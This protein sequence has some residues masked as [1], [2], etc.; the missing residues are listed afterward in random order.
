MAQ[1]TTEEFL[2]VILSQIYPSGRPDGLLEALLKAY[3]LGEAGMET[4]VGRIDR[5]LT[6]VL[7]QCR[8][9]FVAADSASVVIPTWRYFFDAGFPNSQLFKGSGAYHA[10]EL[11]MV[12]GTYNTTAALPCQKNVSAA[13]QK[14]WAEAAQDPTRGP[15]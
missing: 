10:V 7:G 11:E 3:P 1:N 2:H 13:M 12:F 8:I 5:I 14:A 9:K 15:G 6:T 4:E